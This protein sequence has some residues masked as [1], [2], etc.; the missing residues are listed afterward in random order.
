[1]ILLS[2]PIVIF[3][4]SGTPLLSPILVSPLPEVV[5]VTSVFGSI[6]SIVILVSYRNLSS[7]YI[8]GLVG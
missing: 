8:T 3:Y 4:K 2:L 7:K 6:L 5:C 1:M